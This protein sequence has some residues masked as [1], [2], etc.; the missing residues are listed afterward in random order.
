MHAESIHSVILK[1]CSFTINTLGSPIRVRYYPYNDLCMKELSSAE[2]YSACN[3]G[4][5]RLLEL[6][7]YNPPQETINKLNVIN[8]IGEE[9]DKRDEYKDRRIKQTAELQ[10]FN[11]PPPAEGY[12]P[13][14]IKIIDE[15]LWSRHNLYGGAQG[16][17]SCIRA[18]FI[19]VCGYA[20]VPPDEWHRLINGE[21]L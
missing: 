6:E 15:P 5:P 8:L 2:F 19:F 1:I 18:N 14:R 13:F 9:Q 20:N 10:L 4:E 17:Y 21:E 16:Y 12:E 3:S 11:A 7:I